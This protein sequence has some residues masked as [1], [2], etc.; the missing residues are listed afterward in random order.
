M[1]AFTPLGEHVDDPTGDE[2][3]HPEPQPQFRQSQMDI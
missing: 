1:L 3:A 2:E